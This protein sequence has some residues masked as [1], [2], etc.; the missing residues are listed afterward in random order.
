MLRI[1]LGYDAHQLVADRKL[2]LGGIEIPFEKGLLGHSDADVLIHAMM[3]AIL[4]ALSAGSIGDFFPDTDTA[5]KDIYSLN[6]LKKVNQYMVNK[7]FHLVNIDSVIVA[8]RP[9][10]Q[11]YIHPMRT[12]LA[13]TL[14]VS[15]DQV[16][17]K[18]TTT[19][20]MGFEGRQEG[21]SAEA[22]VLIERAN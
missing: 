1:G 10:L 6:L 14:N 22:V 8:Q 2:I 4:G 20:K 18:A 11:P 3:D 5:Y 9:K 12:R 7:G 13:E 17:I 19:E 16:S 21:I 15:I